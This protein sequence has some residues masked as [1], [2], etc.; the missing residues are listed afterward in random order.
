LV[1]ANPAANVEITLLPQVIELAFTEEL[2]V[3]GDNVVNTI[4]LIDPTG[5]P[6][7]L[8]DIAVTGATL[9]ATI[10]EANYPSGSYR[11]EYKIVSADGHKLSE[12]YNFTLNAP[13]LLALPTEASK[14]DG[15]SNEGDG[16]I[17]LPIVGAIAIVVALGGFFALRARKK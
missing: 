10:P 15:E 9:S 1:S 16:V 4:S 7:A 14:E 6:I 13:T 5:A 12:S 2:M 8:S 17:P 11:V 3:I